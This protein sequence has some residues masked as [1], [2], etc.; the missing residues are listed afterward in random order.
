MRR[1][2]TFEMSSAKTKDLVL[3]MCRLRRP[4]ENITVVLNKK[5]WAS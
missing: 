4:H 2:N 5:S 3:D 1:K